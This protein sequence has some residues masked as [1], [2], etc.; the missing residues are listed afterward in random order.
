VRRRASS[1]IRD[2][3]ALRS[4]EDGNS[5]SVVVGSAVGQIVAMH[6]AGAKGGR[7]NGDPIQ[8][9]GKSLVARF[10]SSTRTKPEALRS[11]GLV[12]IVAADHRE[13]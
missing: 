11:G 13:V 8:P 6:F 10:A 7:Q 5:G 9:A 12:E 1:R 4:A 3:K 2:H